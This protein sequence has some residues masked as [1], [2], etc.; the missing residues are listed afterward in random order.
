MCESIRS[1]GVP[2]EPGWLRWFSLALPGSISYFQ[3]GVLSLCHRV[4]AFC[5]LSYPLSSCSGFRCGQAPPLAL[6]A[7][8]S[9]CCYSFGGRY[10]YCSGCALSL[11]PTRSRSRCGLSSWLS[12]AFAVTWAVTVDGHCRF[13]LAI[14][15]AVSYIS[16]PRWPLYRCV[17]H[18]V[19]GLLSTSV[20][21]SPLLSM[22]SSLASA[23]TTFFGWRS[24]AFH[25]HVC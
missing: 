15:K 23:V 7:A 21:L 16:L 11:S 5:R 10:G 22:A 9:R 1:R 17:A 12:F 13:L 8:F 18:A 20:S 24:N 19:P 6:A 3:C 2:P 4:P 25:G 14:A